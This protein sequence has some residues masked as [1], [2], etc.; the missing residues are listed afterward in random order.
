MGE[1][2]V[3][4]VRT[5]LTP[6]AGARSSALLRGIGFE[7]IDHAAGGLDAW[8]MMCHKPYGLVISDYRLKPM[9]GPDVPSSCTR[10]R[11]WEHQTDALHADQP[12]PI[13]PLRRKPRRSALMPFS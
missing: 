10:G 7:N 6:V 12:L 3:S 11:G 2:A 8:T 1:G 4:I 13:L 5:I 9:N